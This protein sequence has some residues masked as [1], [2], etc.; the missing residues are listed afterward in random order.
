MYRRQWVVYDRSEQAY[1]MT[2]D[3]NGTDVTL[4]FTSPQSAREFID[5]LRKKGI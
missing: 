2:V 1:C 5:E 4:T 3:I